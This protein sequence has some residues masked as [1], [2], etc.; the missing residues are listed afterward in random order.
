MWCN[1]S[2]VEIILEKLLPRYSAIFVDVSLGEHRIH[3]LV[4]I[5]GL[6]PARLETDLAHHLEH[7]LSR[8]KAI[9]V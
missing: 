5:L 6:L 2:I 9:L 4:F 8:Q 3:N 7:L 1:Q